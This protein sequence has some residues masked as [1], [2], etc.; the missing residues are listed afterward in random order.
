MHRMVRGRGEETTFFPAIPAYKDASCPVTDSRFPA[1]KK[2][3]YTGALSRQVGRFEIA[4]GT[5]IFL[6]EI[7]DLPLNL[8]VKLLRF[9]QE[10]RFERLGS[11]K[12]IQVD[13]RVIAATNRNLPEAV[14]EGRF[15]E[16]LLYRLNVFPIEIQPLRNRI[17]DIEDLVQAFVREFGD[18]MG[19]RIE[20][21]SRRSLETLK[22][23][24]WPGWN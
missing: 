12:T 14:K 17:G 16:D 10:G 5:T 6:D 15:R 4:H 21:I 20:H 19:K 9:P 2:G 22:R 8:Q 11:P 3:A 24:Q 23:Y 13:V 18:R 7:G 1:I